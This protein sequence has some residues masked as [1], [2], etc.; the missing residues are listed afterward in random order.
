MKRE[1]KNTVQQKA[2]HNFYIQFAKNQNIWNHV[3]IFA[4]KIS[5]IVADYFSVNRLIVS[6]LHD[7][8]WSILYIY[9]HTCL[10]PVLITITH[11]TVILHLPTTVYYLYFI[12]TA[13]ALFYVLDS[14]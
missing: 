14:N 10:Q 3:T 2:R 11:F 12:S 1:K 7:I 9:V 8:M 4:W 6:A 13:D 5:K